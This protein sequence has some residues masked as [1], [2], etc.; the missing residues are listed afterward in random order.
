MVSSASGV[1]AAMLPALGGEIATFVGGNT[2]SEH[3][4]VACILAASANGAISGAEALGLLVGTSTWGGAALQV[5][6][7]GGIAAL[8]AAGNVTTNAAVI[9]VYNAYL[10]GGL[11]L[12]DLVAV[13]AGLWANGGTASVPRY[14]TRSPRKVSPAM[15]TLPP[16]GHRRRCR[17]A[18]RRRHGRWRRGRRSPGEQHAAGATFLWHSSRKT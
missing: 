8:V 18:V 10:D 5:A 6:A 11:A 15:P 12:D 17:H 3:A 9:G 7:G 13:T 1:S 14:S 4:G 16:P 2:G